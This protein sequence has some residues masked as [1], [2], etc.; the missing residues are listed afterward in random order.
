MWELACTPPEATKG[1]LEGQIDACKSLHEMGYAPAIQRLSEIANVDTSRTGGRQT[2]QK[3][4]AR[5]LKGI[6]GSMKPD[7]SGIQ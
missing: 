3:A 6:V 1:T 7:T 4:A 5:F 2:D